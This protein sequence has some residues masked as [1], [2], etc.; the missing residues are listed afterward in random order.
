MDRLKITQSDLFISLK[1]IE[2]LLD[3]ILYN[4]FKAMPGTDEERNFKY[5]TT[6]TEINRHVHIDIQS[7][8]HHEDE[9]EETKENIESSNQP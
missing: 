1:R 2:H 9:E 7:H 5:Q 6:L 4:Q 8:L 3:E